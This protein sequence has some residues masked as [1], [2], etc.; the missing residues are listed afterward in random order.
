MH[1]NSEK[2]QLLFDGGDLTRCTIAPAPMESGPKAI[3]I[4]LL[5]RRNGTQL[6]LQMARNHDTR[7]FHSLDAAW[8]AA[9]KIGFREI[10]VQG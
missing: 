7:Q 2:A 10:R 3:W 4:L 8:S 1:V 5:Q 9:H 6:T